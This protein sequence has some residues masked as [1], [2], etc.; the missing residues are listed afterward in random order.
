MLSTLGSLSNLNTL[1]LN[2]FEKAHIVC[3]SLGNATM[4]LNSTGDPNVPNL[5]NC[6]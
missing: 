6:T 1:N 5:K 3:I 2:I 4:S